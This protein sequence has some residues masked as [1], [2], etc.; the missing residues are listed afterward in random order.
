[1]KPKNFGIFDQ[2]EKHFMIESLPPLYNGCVFKNTLQKLELHNCLRQ[3]NNTV[4]GQFPN[5][6]QLPFLYNLEFV[7][8][9]RIYPLK[10]IR[11]TTPI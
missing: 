10:Y 9:N 5:K 7:Y 1:M 11:R 2:L 3:P 4:I 6:H 8:L